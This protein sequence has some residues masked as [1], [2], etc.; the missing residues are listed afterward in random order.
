MLLLGRQLDMYP[1]SQWPAQSLPCNQSLSK[2]WVFFL[3]QKK[4]IGRISSR[5]TLP[6]L[7]NRS[8]FK[9]DVVD[10]NAGC[11]YGEIHHFWQQ[12]S[13]GSI[14]SSASFQSLQPLGWLQLVLLPG[15]CQSDFA[16]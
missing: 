8:G 1:D 10:D 7:K 15:L 4:L 9:V 13:S 3:T 2:P 5:E 6:H 12:L 16:A 14:S 11:G